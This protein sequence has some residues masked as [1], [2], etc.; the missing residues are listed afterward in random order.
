MENS[1]LPPSWLCYLQSGE[2]E[3]RFKELT[4]AKA[5]RVALLSADCQ[6]ARFSRF[7]VLSL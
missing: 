3:L 5:R 2:M 7:I 6:S 1:A 4:A